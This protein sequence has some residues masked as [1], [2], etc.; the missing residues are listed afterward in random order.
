MSKLIK[1][2]LRN[3]FKQ[4]SFYI[5]MIL[6]LLMI[7]V[8]TFP[9]SLTAKDKSAYMFM[10]QLIAFLKSE[11]AMFTAIFISL[12]VCFDFSEGTVKNIIGRGYTKNEYFISKLISSVISVIIMFII[13][14]VVI[15]ALYIKNG[16]GYDGN[17]IYDIFGRIFL[18]VAA[19][20]LYSTFAFIFEKSGI[21]IIINLFVPVFIPLLFALIDSKLKTN[22]SSIWI[23]SILNPLSKNPNFINVLESLGLTIVYIAVFYIVGSLLIKKKEIK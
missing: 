12:F 17:Y 2:Q 14:S 13:I 3:V 1:F 19:I 21:A 7:T 9:N 6:T 18:L 11:P 5:C 15:F 20:T 8:F 4:K 22:I 10:P 23:D 16:I